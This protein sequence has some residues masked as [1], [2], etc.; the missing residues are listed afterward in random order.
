MQPFKLS[1]AFKD[2]LWGG[3]K[4]KTEYGKQTERSPLAESWELSAH[5]DGPSIIASGPLQGM[6]FTQF[7]QT[8]PKE[9]SQTAAAGAAFP[10]MVKLIDAQKSLSIQVHPGDDYAQRVEGEP[11]KTEMWVILQAEPDAFLYYGFTHKITREEFAQHIQSNTLT[12]VLHKQPVKAGEVYFI[13]AGT[14][15]AIGAGIVLAEIQQSSNSTYRVYDFGRLGADGKPRPLHLQKALDVTLR[16]PASNQAPG[17]GHP[18]GMAKFARR[19]ASCPYFTVDEICLNGEME[20]RINGEFLAFLCIEGTASLHCDTHTL[21]IAKGEC[22]FVPA[23]APS[24]TVE[25]TARLLSVCQ[26]E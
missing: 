11:G 10:L 9:W 19:L 1:P 25:G 17:A 7:V 15:H 18:A 2:Y 6:P 14:I 12:Q 5:A 26:K 22:V 20:D 13:P 3:S 21:Q 16:T 23:S 4:L 8:H 24:F